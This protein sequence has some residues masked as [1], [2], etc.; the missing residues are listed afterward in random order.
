MMETSL[1]GRALVF[2][3]N[4]TGS[5]PVFP[6]HFPNPNSAQRHIV[7][8]YKQGSGCLFPR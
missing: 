3:P 4:D 5:I 2:G 7:L 6:N 1:I 8:S